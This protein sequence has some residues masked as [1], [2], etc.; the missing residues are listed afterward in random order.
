MI[1]I[2]RKQRQN[3]QNKQKKKFL[4]FNK[5]INL[6][7]IKQGKPPNQQKQICLYKNNYKLIK[8]ITNKCK[9]YNKPLI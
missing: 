5:V 2:F 6:F 9:N 7:E 8:N 4:N 1:I 3:S